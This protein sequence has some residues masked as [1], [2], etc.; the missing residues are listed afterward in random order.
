[1]DILF[2]VL[3][4]S[5]LTPD[6]KTIAIQAIGDICLM[7][8]SKFLPKIEQAM[9]LLIEAGK[10]CLTTETSQMQSE[11]AKNIHD[12]RNALVDAFTSMINGIKCPSD[13]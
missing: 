8:E 4:N 10:C 2:L 7:V 5:E 9:D 6:V 11:E 13:E 1:M 12:M 3:K